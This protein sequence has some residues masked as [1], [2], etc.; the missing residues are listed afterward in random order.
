MDKLL[1]ENLSMAYSAYA[2]SVRTE[3]AGKEQQTLHKWKNAIEIIVAMKQMHPEKI[4]DDDYISPLKL[5]A[6]ANNYLKDIGYGKK[7]EKE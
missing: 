3:L 6:L 5:I 1:A 2:R 7:G 4:G